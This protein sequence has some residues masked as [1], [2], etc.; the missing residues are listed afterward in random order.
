M[1]ISPLNLKRIKSRNLAM[2][3]QIIQSS[4]FTYL[5]SLTKLYAPGPRDPTETEIELCLSI[6]YGATGQRWTAA[7]T[8][9]LGVSMA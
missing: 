5:L 1:K 4:T 6:S 3:L 8:G 9:A 2:F 7:G